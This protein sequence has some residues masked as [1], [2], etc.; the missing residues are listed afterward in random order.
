MEEG[1]LQP[2]D[3]PVRIQQATYAELVT[4]SPLRRARSSTY[5]GQRFSLKVLRQH[6]GRGAGTCLRFICD[7]HI[8]II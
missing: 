8:E 7:R 3:G 2:G 1:V 4:V 6:G 5:Q